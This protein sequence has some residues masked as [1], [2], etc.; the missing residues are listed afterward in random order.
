MDI[1]LLDVEG[2]GIAMHGMRLSYRTGSDTELFGD[3]I[4]GDD[5]RLALKLIRE[6]D[7]ASKFLRFITVWIE[8]KAARYWWQQFDTYKV[9]VERLS[10]STMHTILSRPLVADDF[11]G[12]RD[13][14]VD[15]GR[16]NH[17]VILKDWKSVKKLL[18]ES[19][20]QKRFVVTNYQALRR[21]YKDR[22]SHRLDEWKEFCKWAKSYL[23]YSEFITGEK[24]EDK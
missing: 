4:D 22:K 10:E 21:I 11:E 13:L 14:H 7:S 20:L 8:I 1:N 3:L 15:I 16:L 24:D 2:F 23:P 6:S 17:F 5:E 18:P 19:F 9:G 12:Y